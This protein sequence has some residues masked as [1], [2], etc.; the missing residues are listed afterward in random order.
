LGTAAC[1]STGASEP[2]S[3]DASEA[4]SPAANL[5]APDL[6]GLRED[7]RGPLSSILVASGFQ[8]ATVRRGSGG[9]ICG[10]VD[11]T[12]T[13]VGTPSRLPFVITPDRVAFVSSTDAIAI[14]DALD[15]FPDQYMRWCASV[16][17][18]ARMRQALSRSRPD[19][20]VPTNDVAPLEVNTDVPAQ[21]PPPD[22]PP[23][24][25]PPPAPQTERWHAVPPPRSNHS[26]DSPASFFNQIARPG[27][28]SAH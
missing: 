3:S 22:S 14:T 18:L 12:H 17:E 16:E 4:L 6:A 25:P 2:G 10:D 11:L 26:D 9:S 15:A 24:A 23:V 21:A 13:R 8:V 27:A 1:G 5:A 20:N 7:A 19:V 28:D